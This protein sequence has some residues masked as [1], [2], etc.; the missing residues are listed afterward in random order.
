MP[1]RALFMQSQPFF[2]AD[3][4][5]HAQLMR[6]FDRREVEVHVACTTDPEPPNPAMSTLRQLRQI[7]NL[8]VR[9][10]NF[11]PSLHGHGTREQL[12]RAVGGVRLGGDLL[13]LAAYIKR[14]R[15][16]VIHGTEK[17]RDA[18][19]GV[20][21][22]KLTGARSVIH[23]HVGYGDWQSSLVKWAM[24]HADAVVGVSN[25]VAES[26]VKAGY[27]RARIHVVHN[28]L[29]LTGWPADLDGR[30]TRQGLG[31]ASDV[32]VVGII[33]RLFK[34]KG[35]G[36]LIDAIALVHERLPAVKL[37]L[38]G[39]DDPRADPATGS[40]RA[41][42]EAQVR[43]L[44]MEGSVLFTGFR[45]DVPQLMAAFDVFAHPSWEE[46]FGM[47]F[48][49]AMAIQRPVVA[50][51]S[52]GAPEVVIHEQTGLLPERGSVPGLADALV[53]LLENPVLRQR[54]GTAGRQRVEEVFTPQRMCEATLAVYRAVAG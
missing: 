46:P 27:T 22:G 48:L 6:H 2:G 25:F 9:P 45:T 13:S 26:L 12:K 35:Q 41:V 21:L 23:M 42:L 20:L 5:I 29:D 18:L 43:R 15:I 37:V 28:A 14:H 50:W 53:R 4:A 19:Y 32:P 34:W 33:S 11:G 44:G 7:P 51:A 24:N 36:D 31:L 49:E 30:P 52:G 54:F 39:E 38:V 16:D 17:P 3:S 10:T 40:Y 8:F 1:I 47:V